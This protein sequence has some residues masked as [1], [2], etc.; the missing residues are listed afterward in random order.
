MAPHLYAK[1]KKLS[2]TWDEF[3]LL[4]D[5]L[6]HRDTSAWGERALREHS[7]LLKKLEDQTHRFAE[8]R[9]DQR[10]PEAF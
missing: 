7:D 4:K 10:P 3:E 9:P 6:Q 2:L 8:V 1:K 5:C